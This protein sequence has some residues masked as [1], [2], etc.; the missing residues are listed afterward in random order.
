MAKGKGGAAAI[1]EQIARPVVE[2]MGYRLWDVRFEKEG[3]DHFLRVLIEKDGDMSTADCEAVSRALDPL[4]DQADPVEG[5]YYF[6][7]GSPG[8]GRRL[9]R[10]E[11]FAAA[12]GQKVAVRLY[13]AGADGL[14]ELAGL[15]AAADPQ[16]IR[17]QLPDGLRSIPMADLA[18]AKLCD[19]EDLF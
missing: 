13:R 7:V 10:P 12:L 8:L 3:P 18:M 17:L 14:R 5:S 1:V 6:E 15:L 2:R 9:T 19:D 4:I 16:G 11:H